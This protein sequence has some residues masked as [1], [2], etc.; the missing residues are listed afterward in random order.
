MPDDIDERYDCCGE[1]ESGQHSLEC[2]M[3]Q[4]VNESFIHDF[5]GSRFRMSY[6]EHTATAIRKRALAAGNGK[7]DYNG[8]A[9]PA[10]GGN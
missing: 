6:V 1:L 8:W 10:V 7:A 9:I 3:I 2:P 4:R 5:D